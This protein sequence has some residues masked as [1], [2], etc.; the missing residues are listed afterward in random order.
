MFR[1]PC[2]K[3]IV[4]VVCSQDCEDRLQHDDYE[5]MLI[6]WF[7]IILGFCLLSIWGLIWFYVTGVIRGV[8]INL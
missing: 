3:C 2:K 4:E 7:F 1:D 6:H 5:E 8:I